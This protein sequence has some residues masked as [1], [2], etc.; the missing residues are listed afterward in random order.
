VQ[1]SPAKLGT[2]LVVGFSLVCYQV[3]PCCSDQGANLGQHVR[4]LDKYMT[5]DADYFTESF[6]DWHACQSVGSKNVGGKTAMK[7]N[8]S[9]IFYCMEHISLIVF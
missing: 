6:I 5:D 7:I 2:A 3:T 4:G 8:Y 1:E 9:T